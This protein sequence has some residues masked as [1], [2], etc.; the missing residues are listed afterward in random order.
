VE[1]LQVLDDSAFSEEFCHFLQTSVPSVDA[2]ELL[3]ALAGEPL[4]SWQPAEL[5]AKLRPT[6]VM[7]DADVAH[8]LD[9]FQ[10]LGLVATGA[11]GRR[12]Y[13]PADP[14]LAAHVRMLAQAYRE[15]PVTLF[16][17]IYAV[18]DLKK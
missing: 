10:A 11:D 6:T 18:R 3:L 14:A 2:A 16:R 12:E 5:S 9:Q 7:S 13:R 15:R 17:V 1:G 8:H 4:R